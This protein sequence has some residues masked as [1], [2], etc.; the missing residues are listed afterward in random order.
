M[1]YLEMASSSI[2]KGKH[3]FKQE[4]YFDK[5]CGSSDAS[6]GVILPAYYD[7]KL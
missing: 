5:V 2:R 7:S 1:L 3:L 6:L 4:L